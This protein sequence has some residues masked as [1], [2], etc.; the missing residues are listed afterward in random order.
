M[1]E[2]TPYPLSQETWGFGPKS[3]AVWRPHIWAEF[4]PTIPKALGFPT[5]KALEF[6]RKIYLKVSE[7]LGIYIFYTGFEF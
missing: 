5:L 2:L 6:P 4:G 3:L 7:I 1:A